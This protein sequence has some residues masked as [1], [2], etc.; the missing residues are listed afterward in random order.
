[1][2][3]DGGPRLQFWSGRFDD[4]SSASWSFTGQDGLDRLSG[5]TTFSASDPRS[6]RARLLQ[7]QLDHVVLEA[8]AATPHTA[9]R[10]AEHIAALPTPV[11]LFTLLT[12]G[13]MTI[14]A[15]EQS[16]ELQAGQ[17]VVTDSRQPLRY[18]A[19]TDIRMLRTMIGVEHVPTALQRRGTVVPEPLDRTPLAEG[20]A[21]LIS[22]L[23][24]TA[25]EGHLTRSIHMVKAVAEMQ[26]AVL[27]EAQDTVDRPASSAL[28]DRIE[29]YIDAHLTDPDLG[30]PAVAEALGISLRHAHGTFGQDGVTIGRFIRERR[31]ESVAIEL[32][33]ANRMPAPA[34]LAARHGFRSVGAMDRAFRE[35]HG[36]SV[37]DYQR[38]GYRAGDDAR[39]RR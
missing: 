13:R 34:D 27:A 15:G 12:E 36:M 23:L 39:S 37:R 29:D 19:D 3:S 32:R 20:F 9:I 30:P 11:L 17:F 28:R 38:D 16:F 25:A 5:P 21:A 31:I 35:A 2:T 24:R 7:V 26:S 6:F 4:G 1:V 8:F 18:S 10:A 14:H 33:A 22:S